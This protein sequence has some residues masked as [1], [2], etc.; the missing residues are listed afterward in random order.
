LRCRGIAAVVAL[1]ALVYAGSAQACSCTRIAPEAAIREA[2]AVIVGRLIAV[3]PRNAYRSE[4]RYEVVRSYKGGR[5]VRAGR[6]ISVLSA[7][8]GSS[9][10]L[11]TELGRHYGLFLSRQE[12]WWRG[13]LCAAMAP[14]RLASA[15]RAAANAKASSSPL[16]CNS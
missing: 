8:K 9:C 13:G 12:D 3:V 16:S 2:D 1:G 11:P 5:A 15:E 14:R 4:F 6:T 10:G 7:P